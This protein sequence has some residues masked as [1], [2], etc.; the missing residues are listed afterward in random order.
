M[1]ESRKII[2]YTDELNDEFS[3]TQITPRK[4]DGSYDYDG[5]AFTRMIGRFFCYR[6]IAI[7]LAWLFLKITYGH[8]IIGK[9][10]IKKYVKEQKK[11]KKLTG[12]EK[13]FMLYG[14]HT[15]DMA[16]AYIP[17]MITL[18]KPAYVIV[19]ANNV[20]MPFMGKI[21]PYLGAIPLP[22]DLAAGRN[23]KNSISK[24]MKKAWPVV[25]YPE[26]HI[27]PFYTKIRPFKETSFRYP[28]QYDVPVFSFTNTYQKKKL[29]K[30]PKIVTYVDGPFFIN[31]ENKEKDEKMN[32]RNKVYEIM[33]ERSMLN[34]VELIKYIKKGV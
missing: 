34:T 13:G 19:H 3:L 31:K 17:T 28:V 22:D 33:T 23:F 16:D 24:K 1:K 7:P 8:K 6:L 26:A 25:L 5:K 2:Y 14:N 9:D 21:T 27:W 32:L 10:K 4:I 30:K 20:S 29:G 12:T 15:N 18:P 11:Q